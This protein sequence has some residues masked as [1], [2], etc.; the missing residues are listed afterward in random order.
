MLSL[1][2]N[3][4]YIRKATTMNEKKLRKSPVV[5]ALYV[6]AALVLI[7][8][9]YLVGSTVS[10]ISSYYGQYGATPGVGETVG[11]VM[12]SV[13][14]PLVMAILL[15]AAGYILNEV[16][17][18][19]PAYYATKEEIEAAKAAKKAAKAKTENT[20]EV[21]EQTED[22]DEAKLTFNVEEAEGEATVVFESIEATSGDEQEEAL[23]EAKDQL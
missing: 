6:V 3:H 23:K 13:Y 20:V 17:A 8:A 15:G 1:Q 12:Q 21:E 18:L 5:I 22:A 10:Y 4:I 14:Q 9:V 7:Y 11:Y 16:R 19:N 2:S